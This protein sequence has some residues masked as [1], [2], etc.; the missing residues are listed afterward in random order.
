MT[1][2]TTVDEYIKKFTIADMFS[3]YEKLL[4]LK[5]TNKRK[6]DK[7]VKSENGRKKSRESSRRYY[8]RKNNYYHELYNPTGNKRDKDL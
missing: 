6:N 5:A 3:H 2:I 4:K 1:S 7:Y 8:Y